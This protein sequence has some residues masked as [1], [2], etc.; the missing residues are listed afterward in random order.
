MVDEVHVPGG[1]LRPDDTIQDVCG[2]IAHL[3]VLQF[4]QLRQDAQQRV[5]QAVLHL[6][7]VCALILQRLC[8]RRQQVKTLQCHLFL[9]ALAQPHAHLQHAHEALA[10]HFLQVFAH[11]QTHHLQCFAL[12][13]LL[14][15]VLVVVGLFLDVAVFEQ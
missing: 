11:D 3:L 10:Q 12:L 8:T 2:S 9:L 15:H 1:G 7:V 13:T 14:V 5:P 6:F 4:H